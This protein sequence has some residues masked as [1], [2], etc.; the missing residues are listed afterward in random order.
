MREAVVEAKLAVGE[1]RDAVARTERDLTQERQ[2]LADAER[3][4]RLAA[5]IQDR[6]TVDVAQRFAAEHRRAHR[7]EHPRRYGC[8]GG[9]L[10]GPGPTGGR[11]GA[12]R[13]VPRILA[14]TAPHPAE[15]SPPR[16]RAMGAAAGR[17]PARPPDAHAD[18]AE[19]SLR[20]TTPPP[21]SAWFGHPRGLSTLFFTEMWERFSYYGMRGFLI[22]YMTKALGFTDPHAGSVYG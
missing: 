22:L 14:G 5:E 19:R 18:R 2:R 15:G 21:G 6:E 13:R 3:R 10:P 4:G 1:A 12:A 20:V 9:R 17:A 7:A 8:D 16:R 11:D